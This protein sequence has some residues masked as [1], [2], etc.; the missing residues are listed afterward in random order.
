MRLLKKLIIILFLIFIVIF[1]YIFL[2]DKLLNSKKNIIKE[3]D[4][5]EAT[6][7]VWPHE[8]TY[9]REYVE[10]LENTYIDIL[11]KI[12]AYEKS[13]VIIYNEQEKSRVKSVLE[14][15]N[16]NFENVEF[17]IAKTDDIFIS[18]YAPIFIKDKDEKIK[19]V[20]F[21]FNAWG[22]KAL[23]K[24]DN[25]LFYEI[26]KGN[27]YEIV[28]FTDI[29]LSAS[30]LET[31]GRG[32]LFLDK[33]T[34]FSSNKEVDIKEIEENFKKHLG[35]EKIIWLEGLQKDWFNENTSDF[36]RV[37]DKNIILSLYEDDFLSLY[38]DALETDYKQILFA[39]NNKNK[40]FQIEEIPISENMVFGTEEKASYLGFYEGKEVVLVPSYSDTQDEIVMEKFRNIFPKKQVIAVDVEV[41]Y[42]YK[43]SLNKILLRKY[44]LNR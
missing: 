35:I 18:D 13:I 30:M 10:E 39:S 25:N 17:E 44:S 2:K 36:L 31:D 19:A 12:N 40:S 15:E 34:L 32:T 11:K 27:D 22:E 9:S 20:K 38:K 43:A 14:N 23:Y 16:I 28:D 26:L 4:L 37:V 29:S 5:Y 41:L 7:L 21:S 8:Y 42:R 3:D 6:Y 24:N 1:S 33:K